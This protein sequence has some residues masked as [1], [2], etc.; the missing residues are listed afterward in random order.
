METEFPSGA[1]LSNR[2][3]GP[4][5][6]L[7][8]AAFRDLMPRSAVA[9]E[10]K[11]VGLGEHYLVTSPAKLMCLG[12][13]SCV[14]I[15]IY[16][17]HTG[18][19]GMAHA[20]LPRFEEGRDKRNVSKYADS[21]VYVMVDDLLELGCSRSNLRAKLA[22]GAQMFSFLAS[23][24]LNI[25]QRNAE[26]AKEALRNERIPVIGEHLGGNKGR[27]CVFDPSSG[28]YTVQMG[29]EILMI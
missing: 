11:L 21:A 23:D 18:F 7:K 12:L 28:Q 17:I 9:Y 10:N 1:M 20:M 13:G 27:T 5:D 24:S 29:S 25:D 2:R 16:D 4:D 6:C 8:T 3:A 26:S 14:G 15:A 22:G 19:G